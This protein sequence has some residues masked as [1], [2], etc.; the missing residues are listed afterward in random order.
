MS[1]AD[2]YA[3]KFGNP[4]QPAPVQPV[5]PPQQ[6]PSPYPPPQFQQQPAYPPQYAEPQQVPQQPITPQVP[7]PSAVASAVCPQC[8]S[9]NFLVVGKT[10]ASASSAPQDIYRCYDCGYPAAQQAGSGLASLS[11]TSGPARPAKQVPTGG[12]N[13]QGIIGHI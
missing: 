2:W 6:T 1:N 7:L 11:A 10:P 8:R 3:R 12:W 5:Y 4:P 9:R 13:P